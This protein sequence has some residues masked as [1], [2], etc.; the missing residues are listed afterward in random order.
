MIVK[1]Q[2]TIKIINSCRCLVDEE[3]LKRAILW[4]T[5]KPVVQIKKIFIYGKYPAVAIYHEKI[6]VHRLLMM[7]W[8]KRK[9]KANEYVHH[10]N[11]NRYDAIKDNL[12]LIKQATHQS[13]HNKG[14]A[15]SEEHRKKISQANKRRRGLKQRKRVFIPLEEMGVLLKNKYSINSIA[16]HFNCDWSTIKSRIYEHPD[17]LGGGA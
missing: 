3:E 12:K 1:T 11:K 17:L 16:K 13:M 10:E 9:L 6:H 5:K 8:L 15:L 14:K 2:K 4:Y 7:Y